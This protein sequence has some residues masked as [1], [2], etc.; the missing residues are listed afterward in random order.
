[1]DCSFYGGAHVLQLS[2]A[3]LISIF[4]CSLNHGRLLMHDAYGMHV[5]YLFSA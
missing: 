2:R 1:M 4:N 5:A 3:I